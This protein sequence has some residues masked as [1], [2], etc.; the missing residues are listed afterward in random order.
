M[1]RSES[2]RYSGFSTDE[3]IAE[4]MFQGG[5]WLGKVTGDSLWRVYLPCEFL[6]SFLALVNQ[7]FLPCHFC[8]GAR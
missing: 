3:S 5:A 7:D 6:S 1:I 8:L 4:C 2:N